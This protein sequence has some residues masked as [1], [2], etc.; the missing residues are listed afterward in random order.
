M[1]RRSRHRAVYLFTVA[2]ALVL[3]V[4]LFVVSSQTASTG[5]CGVRELRVALAREGVAMGT[6]GADFA[7]V[8]VGSR[9]CWL[10]GYP[11]LQML[12]GSGHDVATLDRRALTGPPGA[13]A[14]KA[15]MITPGAKAYFSVYFEDQTGFGYAVCPR[16]AALWIRAPGVPAAMI[17]RG[18]RARIQPYGGSTIKQLRCGELW[19][20]PVSAKAL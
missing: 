13:G 12:D 17:L 11:R 14:A 10:D 9:A 1:A 6:I 3:A 19:V 2:V 18:P 7:L 5:R 15:V 8:N 16:A 4:A 20:G